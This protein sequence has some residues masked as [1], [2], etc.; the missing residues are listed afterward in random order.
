MRKKKVSEMIKWERFSPY[1]ISYFCI[2]SNDMNNNVISLF[3][4]F[5]LIIDK[6]KGIYI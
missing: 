4:S 1:G 5:I 3:L 2:S 6:I